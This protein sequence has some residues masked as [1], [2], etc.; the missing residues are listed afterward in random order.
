M[1]GHIAAPQK[2]AGLI[3]AG[4]A[5]FPGHHPNNQ[6]P[7]Y[8]DAGVASQLGWLAGLSAIA[9]EAKRTEADREEVYRWR[10]SYRGPMPFW[11]PGRRSC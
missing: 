3:R 1:M 2:L 11:S 8:P 4:E 7:A 5:L 10:L 9:R 6:Q